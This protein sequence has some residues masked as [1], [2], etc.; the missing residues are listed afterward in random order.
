VPGSCP[1]VRLVRD[2]RGA[3]KCL[4]LL[5]FCVAGVIGLE[6]RCAERKFTSLRRRWSSVLQ[7]PAQTVP[8]S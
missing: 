4:F 6:L 3:Q 5:D 8:N 7:S 2:V 1:D